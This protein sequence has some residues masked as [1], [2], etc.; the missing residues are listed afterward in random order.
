M[1]SEDLNGTASVPGVDLAQFLDDT[2]GC[3]PEELAD[4]YVRRS[5]ASED[6][7]TLVKH[8]EDMVTEAHREGLKVRA[9]WWEQR[10]ASKAHVRREEFERATAALLEGLAKTLYVRKLDRLSRRGMGHVGTLLDALQHRAAVWPD[11]GSHR[12]QPSAEGAL[13]HCRSG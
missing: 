13:D 4:L 12:A 1:V 2:T 3:A 9:V 5:K 8:A 7:A 10:S 6:L 11:R